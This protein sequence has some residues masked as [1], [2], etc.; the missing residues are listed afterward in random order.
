MACSPSKKLCTLLH[1]FCGSLDCCGGTDA[2]RRSLRQEI[3]EEAS[4]GS[5]EP[6][7]GEPH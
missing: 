2:D 5:I 4:A 7:F 6:A 1:D 3:R